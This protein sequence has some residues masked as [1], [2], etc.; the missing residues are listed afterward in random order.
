MK[1]EITKDLDKLDY[2]YYL[3][4]NQIWEYEFAD[5]NELEKVLY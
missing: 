4:L 2:Y 5:L 3:N 1:E